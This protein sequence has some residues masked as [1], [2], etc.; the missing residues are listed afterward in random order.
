M[1]NNHTK[2]WHMALVSNG[3][4]QDWREGESLLD[5]GHEPENR[6]GAGPLALLVAADGNECARRARQA[7]NCDPAWNSGA[8]LPSMVFK[9]QGLK[10]PED[11]DLQAA[12]EAAL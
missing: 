6:L 11:C 12:L 10:L 1:Q 8:N 3:S 4:Y 5:W 7:A 2:P 9:I